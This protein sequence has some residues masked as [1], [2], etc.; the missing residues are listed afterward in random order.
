MNLLFLDAKQLELIIRKV[1]TSV[2]YNFDFEVDKGVKPPPGEG[3]LRLLAPDSIVSAFTQSEMIESQK[4]LVL[5]GSAKAQHLLNAYK[6]ERD[7]DFIEKVEQEKRENSGPG[8]EE[9][10]I[11]NDS[12]E[13]AQKPK[14][15]F[16]SVL[17]PEALAAAKAKKKE[18]KRKL[19]DEMREKKASMK[20]FVVFIG[21]KD[22]PLPYEKKYRAQQKQ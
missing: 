8:S 12:E 16:A 20:P 3:G 1:Y 15:L 18:D 21:V 22:N 2:S 5:K 10:T 6:S 14:N 9:N 4:Q 13:E 17:D 11:D 7:A 19:V